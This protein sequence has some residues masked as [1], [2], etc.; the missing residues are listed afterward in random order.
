MTSLRIAVLLCA[1]AG[2]SASRTSTRT[3]VSGSGSGDVRMAEGEQ[4]AVYVCHGNKKKE[5]KKIPE[6]ALNGHEKHGDRVSRRTQ[7]E[8]EACQ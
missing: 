6:S 5:W 3:T 2:C 8:G 1:I 7:K 4:P